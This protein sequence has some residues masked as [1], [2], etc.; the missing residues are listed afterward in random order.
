MS[1]FVLPS[2]DVSFLS[3]C[4]QYIASD[5][6]ATATLATK[7]ADV[8]RRDYRWDSNEYPEPEACEIGQSKQ[9]GDQMARWTNPEPS[10]VRDR[11]GAFVPIT[12]RGRDVVNRHRLIARLNT[13]VGARPPLV[14]EVRRNNPVAAPAPPAPAN[15]VANNAPAQGQTQGIYE[16]PSKIRL[17]WVIRKG[18]V[19]VGDVWRYSHNDSNWG[20]VTGQA[21]VSSITGVELGFGACSGSGADFLARVENPTDFANEVSNSSFSVPIH[22]LKHVNRSSAVRQV[23]PRLPDIHGMTL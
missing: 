16:N 23:K 15:P 5:L 17:D 14:G 13:T 8:R 9:G 7:G 2:L 3:W 10:H 22:P 21:V 12:N 19:M 18:Y 11:D 1:S 20:Q 6:N 4:R